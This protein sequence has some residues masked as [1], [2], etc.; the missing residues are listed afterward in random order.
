MGGEK[1]E[2]GLEDNRVL[3]RVRA[4]A[5]LAASPSSPPPAQFLRLLRVWALP[6]C[7][8]PWAAARPACTAPLETL[9]RRLHRLVSRPP[10]QSVRSDLWAVGGV[11]GRGRGLRAGA[12]FV[13]RGR[14]LRT[15]AGFVGRGRGLST[16][17]G[18]E[19]RG[20]AVGDRC[21][22]LAGRQR[23]VHSQRSQPLSPPD[24]DA[25]G[26]CATWPGRAGREGPRVP[27]P[28]WRGLGGPAAAS[29]GPFRRGVGHQ[30][31]VRAERG[32][33]RGRDASRAFRPAFRRSLRARG[34]T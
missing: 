10:A 13:G 3:D 19:G 23:A 21:T 24:S 2:L 15:G 8:G 27:S 11:V 7:G 20:G 9:S 28:A 18:P 1:A 26:E 14:G 30:E 22:S 31:A 29:G 6:G 4:L 12:G 17:A 34:P 5:G 32:A 25:S 16:W 33:G